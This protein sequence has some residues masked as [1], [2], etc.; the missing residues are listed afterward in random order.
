MRNISARTAYYNMA[1]TYKVQ[2]VHEVPVQSSH[3][4]TIVEGQGSPVNIGLLKEDW[5]AQIELSDGVVKSR[6]NSVIIESMSMRVREICVYID[7]RIYILVNL[8]EVS[9]QPLPDHW[10]HC[11]SIITLS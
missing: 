8:S 1:H 5:A 11:I 4:S 6:M 9:S 2:S 7:Y 10:D 3:L